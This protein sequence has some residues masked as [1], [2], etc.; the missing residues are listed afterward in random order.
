MWIK[1]KYCTII[2]KTNRYNLQ[3]IDFNNL[4]RSDFNFFKV[5]SWWVNIYRMI[6]I[7]QV[8]CIWI[9][10]QLL[11][12]LFDTV[13][14]QFSFQTQIWLYLNSLIIPI[15]LFFL[16]IESLS[17]A[18]IGPQVKWAS[19]KGSVFPNTGNVQSR[20]ETPFAI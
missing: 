8:L 17:N 20:S 12:C 18:Q 11:L 5:K 1:Q 10:K 15:N 14:A 2:K 6:T 4:Q 9:S 19:W 7:C 13:S 3:R 16:I